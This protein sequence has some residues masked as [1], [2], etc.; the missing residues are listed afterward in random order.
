MTT[1]YLVPHCH[2]DVIWAFNK[3][4]YLFIN[5]AIF[6][7]ALKMIENAGFR[8]LVEQTYLLKMMERRAP[9]LYIEVARAI[10][11]KKIEIVDAQYIM[12]D[13]MV[14][15]GEVLVREIL[16]GKRD[17][18]ERF[19][20]D[21]PVA[22]AADGFG[23]NAQM[24]QIYRKSGYKWLAFRRGLPRFVGERVS[25]FVWEGLDGS[26]I[27]THFMPLGYRAGLYLDQWEESVAHLKKTATTSHLMMP[28]G[29][30]GA[31]PQEAIPDR[32]H[33]W[34]RKHEEDEM[35]LAT[36]SQFFEGLEKE[37]SDLFVYKGELF[38]DELE[39][40]FPDS[41]SSR[42][43]LKQAIRDREQAI[44]MT[45]KMCALTHIA[46]GE[47]PRSR[48]ARMW[49]RNLFLANHDVV[50]GCGIDEIY[51]EPW[52][53]IAELEKEESAVA[54]EC[55]S[56]LLPGWEHGIYVAV[57]NPNSWRVRNWVEADVKIG[58]GWAMDPG[59]ALDGEDIPSQSVETRRW[60]DGTVSMTRIGFVAEVPPLSFRVYELRKQ[61]REFQGA[62]RVEDGRVITDAFQ[63]Q[64]DKESGDLKVWDPLGNPLLQG[65]EIIIDEEVGDLYFHRSLLGKNIGSESGEGLHFGVFKPGDL[66]IDRGPARTEITYRT[67]FYCLRWPYYL[68]DKFKPVLFRHKTV[69]VVKRIMV[70]DGIPRIDIEVRLNLLQPHVRL[71]LRFDT[72]MVAPVYNRETHFGVISLPREKTLRA[73]HKVPPLWWIAGEEGGRGLALLTRGIPVDEIRGGEIF[74][75]LLRSVSVLSADGVSGPLIPTPEAQEL[76]EHVY[77]CSVYPYQGGWQEA[78]VFRRDLESRQPLYPLKLDRKP[79]SSLKTS[80]ITLAPGNLVLSALKKAEDDDSVVMRF[81]ETTGRACRARIGV[82]VATVSARPLNLLEE[83]AG[84][85]VEIDDGQIALDVG[86]FEIV[87]LKLIPPSS[88]KARGEVRPKPASSANDSGASSLRRA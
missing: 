9:E 58:E 28:C 13:P 56:H 43:R 48:I 46:G 8:F 75:T 24:P 5:I 42:A 16:H 2:Y 35:V 80:G 82:P 31:I 39:D 21:V 36:P 61:T 14:P 65:A 7:K 77:R 62:I 84:E 11:D 54:R 67:S 38:S 15:S 12:A 53:Y 51:D 22:W 45:E 68:I 30:G 87:T 37:V 85:E 41:V 60:D 34:N 66:S 74:C 25:E 33:D 18:R 49:R 57:F 73:S 88:G 26:Q 71:R 32:L 83:P 50:R 47:Y 44:I 6:K 64:V 3:D 4:D 23:L 1:I 86:P 70:Y 69:D 17:C 29:S 79:S 19:Q 78:E 59:I 52:E 10:R 40:V 27:L 55:M 63:L 20:V 76:G 81:Y 72:K